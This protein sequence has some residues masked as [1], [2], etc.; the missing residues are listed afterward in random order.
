MRLFADTNITAQAVRAMRAAGHDVTYSGE[1]M[2]DPGDIAL[3]AEDTAAHRIFVTKDHDIGELVFA[4]SASHAGVI[5]IDDLGDPTAEAR[6]L[7]SAI[8]SHT[9]E[10]ETGAFVRVDETGIRVRSNSATG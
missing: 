10:L 3:L 7:L 5:L 4:R 9:G 6:M 2:S 8:H 1:R